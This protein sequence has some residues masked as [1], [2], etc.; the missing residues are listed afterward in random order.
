M[1]LTY[2]LLLKLDHGPA[3]V[4]ENLKD[5]EVAALRVETPVTKFVRSF[6]E[7]Q[8][9]RHLFLTGN[10][11]DGKTFAVR[12]AQ[13]GAPERFA[14]IEVIADAAA[15]F[16]E[17]DDPIKSLAQRMEEALGRDRRLLVAINRGQLERLDRFLK[18][19]EDF[20]R[21]RP[22]IGNA[23]GQLHLRVDAN[24]ADTASVLVLDLGLVDTLSDEVVDPFLDRL[25]EVCPD[26]EMTG[27]TL[28]ALAASKREL[29]DE[30]VRGEI[31]SAFGAL[32]DLSI[33]VT[34]R[35]LWSLGAFLLTG[36]RLPDSRC[37]L[38]IEDSV[39]ARLYSED[40]GISLIERLRRTADPSL[41]PRPIAAT[42]A[43]KGELAERFS[44]VPSLQPFV[45]QDGVLAGPAA[46]RVSAAYKVT[47]DASPAQPASVFKEALALLQREGPG[48]VKL[49]SASRRLIRGI[50]RELGLPVYGGRFPRWQQ[51]CYDARHL[52]AA[53]MVANEVLDPS[54]FA[55][56]LPRPS[57]MA[58]EAFCGAWVPPALF[59]APL[60]KESGNPGGALRLDPALFTRLY[61]EDAGSRRPLPATRIEVLRRW[62]AQV[63]RDFSPMPDQIWL[64]S[65]RHQDVQALQTDD[66]AE[67]LTFA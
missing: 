58:E 31:R 42:L 36:W 8:V 32:R 37:P 34:M 30:V 15:A 43:L 53:T 64:A 51:L 19:E 3:A 26:G 41:V 66:L 52:P 4:V 38:S 45:P 65:R 50:F 25:C 62:L 44:R 27:V 24:T 46:L 54:A 13:D 56:G 10:A 49:Q 17:A 16:R 5:H 18:R 48:W 9:P 55:L 6:P 63:V 61:A 20:K 21:L 33:H 39:A 35:Q 57:G 7:S 23:L 11:G 28:E 12:S 40:S 22:V 67:G 47:N 14:E 60:A 29:Q 2:S 59:F 1:S